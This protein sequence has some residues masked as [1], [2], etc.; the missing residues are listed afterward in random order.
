MQE[1]HFYAPRKQLIQPHTY[2]H[3]HTTR[4]HTFHPLHTHAHTETHKAVKDIK[5]A[6]KA[7]AKTQKSLDAKIK[8]GETKQSLSASSYNARPPTLSVSSYL[9]ALTQFAC[10]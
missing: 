5:E 3:P 1:T 7:A 9:V 2:T 10:D 4:T 6:A 8:K